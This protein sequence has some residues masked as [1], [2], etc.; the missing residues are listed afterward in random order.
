MSTPATPIPRTISILKVHSRLKAFCLSVP[1]EYRI[2]PSVF[3]LNKLFRD[4]N[5]QI[6]TKLA[7][8]LYHAMERRINYKDSL[9]D[10]PHQ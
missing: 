6:Q 8:F 10:D 7:L 5:E 3:K 2:S 9:N 4:S 1:R